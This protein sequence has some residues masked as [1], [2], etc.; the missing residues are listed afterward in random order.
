[1]APELFNGTRVDERCDVYS[2]GCIL[3]E[4]LARRPPFADLTGGSTA[5]LFK[6]IVAVAINGQRPRLP[7]DFPPPL[8]AVVERCW[9]QD[10]RSRPSALDLVDAFDELIAASGGG[11]ASGGSACSGAG[12]GSFSD[13][14]DGVLIQQPSLQQAEWR[15]ADASELP[16]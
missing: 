9:Q 13:G 16:V 5:G 4:A 7:P 14:R 15:P 12:G 8:R 11:G 6:I 1:M 10:P 3:Y 2:L